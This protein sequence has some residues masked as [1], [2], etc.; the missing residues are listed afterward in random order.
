MADGSCSEVLS[1][2]NE[3]SV[4]PE[5]GTSA[6]LPS[7]S[8]SFME[9]LTVG[10]N[11]STLDLILNEIKRLHNRFDKMEEKINEQTRKIGEFSEFVVTFKKFMEKKR[12]TV[13]KSAENESQDGSFNEFKVMKRVEDEAS[14]LSLET[15]L[16]EE[17][18]SEKFS[19][20]LHQEYELNGKRDA[21]ALFK[22]LLRK[23][24][25]PI[26]LMPYSWKGVS[27]SNKK[28]EQD[29]HIS[30][31][32][33]FPNFISFIDSILAASDCDYRTEHIDKYFDQF[34]RQKKKE[35]Q[36]EADR[37]ERNI[38]PRVVASRPHQHKKNSRNETDSTSDNE[39]H[40]AKKNRIEK[41]GDSATEANIK[42]NN[43]SVDELSPSS[44]N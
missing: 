22:I 23:I 29:E 33:K 42:D 11:S 38:L 9:T 18:Y 3:F 17:A 34:L 14:F 7:D 44:K 28:D 16:E 30:F 21:N 27:R 15:A 35:I 41:D 43:D 25:D 24:V 1:I 26:A 37:T 8:S 2:S 10:E 36:R 4:L 20:Y 31:K 39:E 6:A 12:T 13:D 19:R 5:R 32:T 40:P